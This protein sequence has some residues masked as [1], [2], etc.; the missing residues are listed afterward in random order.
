M[1][2]CQ[3]Q[4]FSSTHR[5]IGLGQCDVKSEVGRTAENKLFVAK[6]GLAWVACSEVQLGEF[7]P[8]FRERVWV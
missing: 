7:L 4:G 2:P 5:H 3:P 8:L 6:R 1:L